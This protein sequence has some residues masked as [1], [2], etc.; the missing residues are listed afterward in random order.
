MGMGKLECICHTGRC[1]TYLPTITVLE[2]SF[3]CNTESLLEKWRIQA[4]RQ[5]ELTIRRERVASYAQKKGPGI[6]IGFLLSKEMRP[7]EA[8][9]NRVGKIGL[10]DI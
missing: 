1:A 3:F 6:S 4:S 9:S 8:M 5:T 2:E 10:E 7:R